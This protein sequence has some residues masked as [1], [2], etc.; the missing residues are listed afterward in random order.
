VSF[1]PPDVE[2]V[3]FVGWM[4]W[5]GPRPAHAQLAGGADIASARPP[6][7]SFLAIGTRARFK[8]R[9]P[10]ASVETLKAKCV[11]GA[12]ELYIGRRTSCRRPLRMYERFGAGQPLAQWTA[13]TS[14]RLF[15]TSSLVQVRSPVIDSW[16][17]RAQ[18]PC[19]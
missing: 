13:E 11:S 5:N 18:W 7:A 14:G 15:L 17:S 4:T 16:W 12:H 1:P 2:A 6:S 9:D 10:N 8:R 3:E 19:A